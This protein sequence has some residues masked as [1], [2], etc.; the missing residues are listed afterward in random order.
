MQFF[1]PEQCSEWLSK[2]NIIGL[3]Y[4][5]QSA[6][7]DYFIQF[8]PPE[9][10][11]QLT[12]LIRS[13]FGDFGNFPGALVEFKDWPLYQ[14]DE[15]ALIMSLRRSYGEQRW[16]I[17]A[18]GHLFDPSEQNEAISHCYLALIF[19]WSAYLYL[20][21]GSITMMFWE[22]D[23]IDVWSPDEKLCNVVRKTVELYKLRVTSKSVS[24]DTRN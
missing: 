1:T 24:P 5:C 4:G 2:H 6:N 8:A 22:G 11:S 23:L 9:K 14:P 10:A 7:K 13:L 17:H 20:T 16:L 15:M 12:A 3:P 18:P 21:S 19:G